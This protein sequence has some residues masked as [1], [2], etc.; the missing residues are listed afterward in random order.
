M[1]YTPNGNPVTTFSVAVNRTFNA[2][3]GERREETEWFRVVAWNALAERCNQYL[4]KGQKV[5]V[6]GRLRTDKWEGRDGTPRTTIEIV[7]QNVV[8]MSRPSEGGGAMPGGDDL[9]EEPYGGGA[10]EPDLPF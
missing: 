1:R 10:P 7:A 2:Q 6:D 5:Y 8:F 9:S 3:D 4:T